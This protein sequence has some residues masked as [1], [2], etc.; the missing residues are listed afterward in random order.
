MESPS[1]LSIVIPCYNESEVLSALYE[2][3]TAAAEGVAGWDYELVLV[4]DG[5]AD[6]TRAQIEA[7]SR[8]DGR[9]VGV[10]LSRN[11]G[12]QLALTAGLDIARG[13]RVFIIDADLQDPP[14]LL[15]PMMARMDAGVDVVYGQRQK[16]DGE[17]AFKK[18]SA[19][20]FYRFLNVMSDVPIPMDTG[21]FRLMS[22]KALDVLQGMPERHRFIRGMVSWIGLR[23]EAFPYHRDARFA[24]ETKYPLRK[25]IAFAAD[26][27]TSFS[28][29]PLKVASLAGLVSA[30][31]GGAYL[32]FAVTAFLL[33]N[34]TPG[35]A[36]IVAVVLVC[37][38]MQL[39][40]LG[41]IGEYLGRLYMEA[42]GRP[43][44][45]IDEV[46]GRESEG[47]SPVQQSLDTIEARLRAG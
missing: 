32:L 21:D 23:Q 27:V 24:G 5:S 31:L 34:T 44:Y 7:L 41:L 15:T 39:L 13:D 3:V 10:F 16:R 1:L 22:R 25:M 45:V 28:I 37:S 2:R 4:N 17:T 9:V 42:K 30:G 19:K 11:H 29:R 18:L 36:S 38:A 14:E 46:V 12:H 40:V 6:D 26:A 8:R 33:G 47:Q 35:W 20:A 43:L